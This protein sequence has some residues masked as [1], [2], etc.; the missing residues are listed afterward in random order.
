M[1]S[2]IWVL[3]FIAL[4]SG[5]VPA[6]LGQQPG[7]VR[8]MVDDPTGA[9]VPQAGVKLIPQATGTALEAVTDDQGQFV[10]TGVAPGEYLLQVKMKGFERAE[11]QLT[12]GTS[13]PS[14]QR[15]RLKVADVEEE[16]VVSARALDPI[17]P[18]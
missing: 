15:L 17:S 11:L 10:F 8:G 14:E 13:P 12:V 6:L 18:D 5:F 1:K 4:V 7:Q 2:V 9:A 3:F 16:I